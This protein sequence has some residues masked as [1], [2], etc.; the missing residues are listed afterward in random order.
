[1][2][3]EPPDEVF[4]APLLPQMQERLGLPAFHV[5][6]AAGRA[7]SYD[8]VVAEARKWLGERAAA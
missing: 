1:L 4:L 5:A 7:Q 6:E 2:H 3:R 8:E